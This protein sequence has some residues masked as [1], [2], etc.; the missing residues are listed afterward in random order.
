M[1]IAIIGGG[2]G[3]LTTAIALQKRGIAVTVYERSPVLECIGAG[4]MLAINAM[5]VMDQLG[6]SADIQEGGHVFNGMLITQPDLRPLSKN[7]MPYFIK[8]LGYP[9]VAIHRGI[10]QK[11]LVARLL[12]GTLHTNKNCISLVEKDHQVTLHFN[13]GSQVIADLVIGADGIHSKARQ[14]L[15]KNAPLRYAGQTCWR[16]VV[17]FPDEG[18]DWSCLLEAWGRGRRFGFTRINSK[19]VYWYALINSDAGGTDEKAQ[20]KQYLLGIFN[21]F[22]DTILDVIKRTPADAIFRQDI[23]DIK[24]LKVWHKGRIGILGDAAHATTPNLGQ[25]AC[26]AIEDAI[27]IA[28]LIAEAISKKELPETIFQKFH[29][30]RFERVAFICKTSAEIGKL[31]QLENPILIKL[32]NAMMKCSPEFLNKKQFEKIFEA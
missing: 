23:Y 3:G 32:R 12:P 24:P 17:N 25:G 18:R 2:I 7:V 6:M 22:S 30:A 29:S 20:L 9:N 15:T 26:Q 8:K 27:G 4:L 14:I 31:A 16:G 11:L 1:N 13:D 5:Q 10:L 19:E 28:G 21:N